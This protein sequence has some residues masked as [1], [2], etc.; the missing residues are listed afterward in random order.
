MTQRTLLFLNGV[1]KQCGVY[2]YGFRVK[3]ILE[4][5]PQIRIDYREVQSLAEFQQACQSSSA[6]VILINYHAAVQPWLRLQDEPAGKVCYYLYHESGGLHGVPARRILNT[7]PLNTLGIG[8]GIPRPLGALN[9]RPPRPR[10]AIEACPI[11]G[12]FGFGFAHKGFDTIV[13]RVQEQFDTAILRFRMP[14]AFFGDANGDEARRVAAMCRQRLVKPGIR[15]DIQHDFLESDAELTAFLAENDLNIFLYESGQ[16]RG[17]S[18]VIDFALCVQRPI[19]ISSSF[20]FRH[21]YHDAICVEKTP[22]RAILL[23][24]VSYQESLRNAWAPKELCRVVQAIC[25]TGDQP[26]A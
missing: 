19:A 14:Y 13:Q 21:I 5:S 17:C 2:Q 24:D 4:T 20:M 15:L 3:T 22:L 9:A 12:S 25:F 18:S 7:D 16:G 8:R 11:I 1:K 10:E 26:N 6:T 23:G